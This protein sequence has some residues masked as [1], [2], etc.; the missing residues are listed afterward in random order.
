M[1]ADVTANPSTAP[2]RLLSGAARGAAFFASCA[3]LV[4]TEHSYAADEEIY[5]EGE[6]AEYAY[7]VIRG[8][9]RSYKLL[10][11]GR[12]QINAFHLPGDLF[13]LTAGANHRL[14]AEAIVGTTIRMV[15]RKSLDAASR[16]D[17]QIACSLF[18]STAHD[19]R[20][21]EDHMLL[22]GCKSA[23]EK[24]ASFLLEMDKR[25]SKSGFIALPMPRR[26]IGDYLGLTIETVSRTVTTLHHGGVVGLSGARQITLQDRGRLRALSF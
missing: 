6:P 7:E 13:G 14:T 11:D 2:V 21:A 15:K 4:S 20:H 10:C 5:G 12:R 8:A 16:A 9:V 3:S 22:L 26:D 25:L 24:V 1:L 18:A 23:L 17:S 19:L